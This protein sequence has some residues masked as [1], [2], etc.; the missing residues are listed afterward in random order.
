MINNQRYK[1]KLQ[2]KKLVEHAFIPT[3]GSDYAAGLDI[4]SCVEMVVP[5]RG[6]A[7]VPTGLAIMWTGEN[8]KEYYMRIAPRSGLSVKNSIDIGAGVIDW[9]YRG[10]VKICL[11]NN[12][13]NDF[14]IRPGDRVAQMILERINRFET[15]EQV[16]SLDST[17][18]GSGGFGSTGIN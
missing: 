5:A 9:D 15:I 14:W 4:C 16:D 11:C 17:I 7:I 18:R 6:R 12:S 2:I 3:Y 8:E 10:E 13:N 1:M